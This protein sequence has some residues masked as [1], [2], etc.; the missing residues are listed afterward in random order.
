MFNL[1]SIPLYLFL[2]LALPLSAAV[3]YTNASPMTMYTARTGPGG[4][5]GNDLIDWGSKP[6]GSLGQSFKINSQNGILV[7]VT[8]L[9]KKPTSNFFRVNEGTYPSG[10]GGNFPNGTK[11]LRPE[12][13]AVEVRLTFSQT[14]YGIGMN[15]GVS[16]HG[17]N[18]TIG[19]YNFTVAHGNN[20]NSANKKV[21]FTNTSNSG[22]AGFGTAPFLGFLHTGGFNTAVF[23]INST[24]Y[25]PSVFDLYNAINSVALITNLVSLPEPSTYLTLGSLLL[26]IYFGVSLSRKRMK[27]LPK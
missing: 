1:K 16:P 10:F 27:S 26:G 15:A 17:V 13:N 5:N 22:M 25:S 2:F 20:I 18:L 11:L 8:N 7:T 9:K 3:V 23:A 21:S 12:V 14:I 19:K 6:L 4:M 24:G